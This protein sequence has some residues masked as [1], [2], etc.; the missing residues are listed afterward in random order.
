MV[1]IE[2]RDDSQHKT[3]AVQILVIGGTRFIGP[4]RAVL[5]P[6]RTHAQSPHDWIY[7][8]D[9]ILV[10]R[11]VLSEPLIPTVVLRLPKVYGRGEH[12]DFSTI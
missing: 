7:S 8:Y 5:D 6:Y 2:A 4:L 10:E 11:T 9:K 12:A 1:D 3:T